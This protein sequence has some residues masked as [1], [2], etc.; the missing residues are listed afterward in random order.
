M[1]KSVPVSDPGRGRAA[2]PRQAH[3]KPPVPRCI[4]G[5]A[6]AVPRAAVPRQGTAP[7]RDTRSGTA[8]PGT[9]E[10]S[11][12]PLSHLR[13]GLVWLRGRGVHTA[14]NASA[15]FHF[16][17]GS[18]RLGSTSLPGFSTRSAFWCFLLKALPHPG[19]AFL[20]PRCTQCKPHAVPEDAP[21][22]RSCRHSGSCSGGT[23]EPFGGTLP[24]PGFNSGHGYKKT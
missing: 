17:A 7:A 19:N 3:L 6:A 12:R 23:G 24:V 22:P 14:L 9:P 13:E 10:F 21:G 4:P 16:R 11:T 18:R 15:R 8:E 1:G 5:A 20:L 2:G